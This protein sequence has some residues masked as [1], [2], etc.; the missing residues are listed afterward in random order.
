MHALI[1][2]RTELGLDHA[3]PVVQFFDR[4]KELSPEGRGRALDADETIATIHNALVQQGNTAPLASDDVEHHYVAFVRDANSDSG[5]RRIVELDG[6]YKPGPQYY[7]VV[8]KP[9]CDDLLSTAVDVIQTQYMSR[10]DDASTFSILL[11]VPK[12]A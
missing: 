9:G 8:E 3:A 2:G 6:Y 10:V 5:T 4:T 11:V 7:P 1:N 12:A